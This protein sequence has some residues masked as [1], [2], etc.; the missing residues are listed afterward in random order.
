M[1][2]HEAALFAVALAAFAVL[3]VVWLSVLMRTFYRQQLS[4]VARMKD[5]RLAPIWPVA[6]LVYIILALAIVAFAVPRAAGA[7]LTAAMWGGL[8]GFVLYGF[9]NF[10]NYATLAAWSPAMTIVD[11]LWG[12][13]ACGAVAMIVTT[14]GGA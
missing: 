11:T 12:S 5:G 9:Y 3:D 14:F 4:G 10:T 1:S 6:A 8:L 2:T 7:P 13:A